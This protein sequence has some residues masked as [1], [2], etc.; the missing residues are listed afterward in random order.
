[1]AVFISEIAQHLS[2]QKRK[3][4]MKRAY[5]V[6][7]SEFH[8]ICFWN[9]FVPIAW[10]TIKLVIDQAQQIEGTRTWYTLELEHSKKFRHFRF[11][12]DE[13]RCYAR[14]QNESENLFRLMCSIRVNKKILR[15]IHFVFWI[16]QMLLSAVRKV[17]K[18]LIWCRWI[19]DFLFK[20]RLLGRAFLGY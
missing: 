17:E 10:V 18:P 13:I 16:R 14:K 20:N 7:F 11:S 15:Q 1:M 3:Q 2:I 12:I 9:S 4:L 5:S 19:C 8:S 6:L